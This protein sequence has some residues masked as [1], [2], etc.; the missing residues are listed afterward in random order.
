MIRVF[1]L[2]ICL[3]NAAWAEEQPS[4]LLYISRDTTESKQIGIPPLYSI[5]V[6][7][8]EIAKQAAVKAL[9]PL[10]REID[11]C[12]GMKQAEVIAK[13]KPKLMFMPV[14]NSFVTQVSL[15]FYLGNG[16]R[17]G[18]VKATGQAYGFIDSVYAD[19]IVAKSYE[20]AMSIIAQEYKA[21]SR[22]QENLRGGLASGIKTVPCGIV[23]FQEAE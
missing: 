6:D 21:D 4:L 5:W 22:L 15:V 13:I 1:L 12:D 11:Q 18:S 23:G 7:R 2:L 3:V 20:Q 19:K 16:Q 14:E 17:I 10:F 9:A 8:V